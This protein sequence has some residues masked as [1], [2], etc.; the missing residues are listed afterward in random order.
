VAFL[1]TGQV[2]DVCGTVPCVG[3]PDD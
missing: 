3:T 2:I 1:T